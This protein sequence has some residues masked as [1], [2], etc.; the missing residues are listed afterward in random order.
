M[1]R[2][3]PLSAGQLLRTK[4]RKYSSGERTFVVLDIG[5]RKICCLVARLLPP[6]AWPEAAF[7]PRIR[8]LGFGHQL[9][10]GILAGRISDMDAAE[11]SVRGAVAKAERAADVM[12]NEVYVTASFGPL[13]SESFTASVD[14][15][16]GSVTAY[17]MHRVMKA[18]REYAAR[19]GKAVLHAAPFGRQKHT[20][21]AA[22][23]GVGFAANET[24][25]LQELEDGR[26]RVRV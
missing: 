24:P 11:R 18:A 20:A 2:R 10:R 15:P 25:P 7:A 3:P 21:R 23:T 22:V 12:V 4:A 13:T 1:R 14:L 5:T 19:G 9:S 26:Y 17:D 16:A 8:I 6:P